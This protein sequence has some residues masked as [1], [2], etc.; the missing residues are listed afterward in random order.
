MYEWYQESILKRGMIILREDIKERS[1]RSL[2]NRLSDIWIRFY[3][4]ILPMLQAVFYTIAT[5]GLTI[6]QLTLLHFRDVVVLKTKVDEAVCSDPRCV[7]QA[8]RQMFL[9][10]LVSIFVTRVS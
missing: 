9:V 4:T 6:R 3:G 2:L 8:L 7:S 10:L 1:G 5:H